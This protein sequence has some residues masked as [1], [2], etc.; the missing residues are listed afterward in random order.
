MSLVVSLR[1]ADGL[2]LA[3][4]S[5]STLHGQARITGDLKTKCPKCDGEIELKDIKIPPIST[6]S[7]T[8]SFAQKVF[9]FLGKFGIAS[10]GMGILNQKTIYYHLKELE[11][12]HSNTELNSAND[13]AELLK[14]YFAEEMEK[15]IKDLCKA[16]DNFYPLGFQI[17]GYDEKQEG[18]TIEVNVGKK[19][20]TRSHEGIGCT[21]SGDIKIVIQLWN[22]GK[23][24]PGQATDYNSFSLQD[25]IDYTE[26]LI[27]TTAIYQRFANMLPTVGGEVD[28]ALITPFQK[29]SW[30]KTKKLT[31]IL[32][33]KKGGSL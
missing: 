17:I 20:R 24:H 29:F 12:V 25:A 2:V 26:F 13:L 1:I 21:I 30:I 4:D 19:S 11:G 23:Q 10:W 27:N 33:E 31:R 8:R 28:V 32:E 18:K 14:E 6:A 5:L 15:Q 22:L 16:P 3:A 7:S 9:P